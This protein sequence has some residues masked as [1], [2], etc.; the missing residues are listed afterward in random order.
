MSLLDETIDSIT[1][2]DDTWTTGVI[3]GGRT[4][5]MCDY[6]VR[7]KGENV[8]CRT[9]FIRTAIEQPASA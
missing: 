5:A 2:Q 6:N 1:G 8:T 9:S 7:E 3:T 4:R